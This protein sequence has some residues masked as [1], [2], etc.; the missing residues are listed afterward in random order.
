MLVTLAIIPNQLNQL[1]QMEKI[2]VSINPETITRNQ[3]PLMG[4]LLSD[5]GLKPAPDNTSVFIN[6]TEEPDYL[7]RRI[8]EVFNRF[9]NVKFQIS[10][11]VSE[12]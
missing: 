1:Y 12:G 5:R 3:V 9:P 2:I 6:E 11:Y 10:R 8:E 4:K 7:I